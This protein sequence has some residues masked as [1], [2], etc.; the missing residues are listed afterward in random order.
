MN[1]F[2]LTAMSTILLLLT[3]GCQTE[4]RPQLIARALLPADT[5]R[6]QTRVGLYIDQL[7]NGRQAPFAGVPVQGFSSVIKLTGHEVLALQDN[8]FGTMAN[9]P[10][11]PL[12]WYRLRLNFADGVVSLLQVVPLSDPGCLLPLLPCQPD[13]APYLHGADLDP[14][15]FVRTADGTMWVGEEFGPWLIPCDHLGRVIRTPFDVPVP[16]PLR[17][18]GRGSDFYRSPDHPDVKG[19]NAQV[20]AN[21][22]RSGGLEGLALLPDEQHLIVAVEKALSDDPIAERR[23]L[24][25][26]ALESPRFTDRYWF[27][28]MDGPDLSIA[29]LE[30]VGPNALLIV[31]RDGAEGP[32]A[33]HKRIYRVDLTETTA[34]GFLRKAL[35]CDL[36]D[37]DD[38]NGVTRSEPGTFGL[39]HPYAFPYV[40]PEC[41]AVWGPDTLL[42]A[43]DNNYPFSTGRRPGD[44]PDDNEFIL[45]K[46]PTAT[47]N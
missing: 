43:N 8:G 30:A 25:E 18:F 35:V 28:R 44:Q 3:C 6:G 29:S 20:Q 37:I 46:L 7:T 17:Q 16:A 42:I 34:D 1:R 38:T 26:F 24:L 45:V 19:T 23:V 32:D 9:S 2:L 15:S 22:P 21:L 47:P 33:V 31:E 11:Y 39:G 14:E 27:Y 40:T 4:P 36:L 13:R 41:L 5:F 10:D 12:L